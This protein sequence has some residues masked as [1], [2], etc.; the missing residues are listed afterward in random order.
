MYLKNISYLVASDL[1]DLF[2][3]FKCP[4]QEFSSQDEVVQLLGRIHK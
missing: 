3:P 4:M 1:W 2:L